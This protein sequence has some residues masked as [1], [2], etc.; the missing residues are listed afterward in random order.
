MAPIN[1]VVVGGARSPLG[2]LSP[3]IS[4]VV[5]MNTF[6]M[7]ATSLLDQASFYNTTFQPSFLMSFELF[8]KEI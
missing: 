2:T 4:M 1:E 8:D 5:V 3:S 6:S 7:S